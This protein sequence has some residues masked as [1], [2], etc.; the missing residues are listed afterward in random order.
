MMGMD[1]LLELDLMGNASMQIEFDIN[2]LIG[3]SLYE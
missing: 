2:I 1:G 3:I